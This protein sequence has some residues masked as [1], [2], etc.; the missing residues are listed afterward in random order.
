MT[1]TK[2]YWFRA[3]KYGWGWTPA[4][5]QGWTIIVIY[6]LLLLWRGF[7]VKELFD[8]ESSFVFRYIFE[9]VGITIPLI[10]ICYLTGEK[11]RWRWGK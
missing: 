4:S 9:L 10:I 7:A 1:L 11:P 2:N 3:K 5:W 8:T 6:T